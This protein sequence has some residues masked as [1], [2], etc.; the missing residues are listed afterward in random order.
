MYLSTW[1]ATHFSWNKLCPEIIENITSYLSQTWNFLSIFKILSYCKYKVTN[2]FLSQFV[3]VTFSC[4]GCR[5]SIGLNLKSVQMNKHIIFIS[6][7]DLYVN[8]LTNQMEY[9][10]CMTIHHY[11]INLAKPAKIFK[12]KTC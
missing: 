10:C 8:H 7:I 1:T 4:K 9:I 5:K 2:A 6:K 11:S 12:I 3:S